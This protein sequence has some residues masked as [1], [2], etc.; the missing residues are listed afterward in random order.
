MP[1]LQAATRYDPSK[2][3]SRIVMGSLSQIETAHVV[4]FHDLNSLFDCSGVPLAL[5]GEADGEAPEELDDDDDEELEGEG[6]E[7]ST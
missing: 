4:F 6:E 5:E 1:L 3:N 7:L 2:L